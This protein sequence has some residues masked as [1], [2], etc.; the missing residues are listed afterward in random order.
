LIATAEAPAPEPQEKQQKPEEPEKHD[1][2]QQEA[3]A[4]SA[5]PPQAS[6]RIIWSVPL[7]LGIEASEDDAASVDGNAPVGSKSRRRRARR[8]RNR[9]A[10]KKNSA[11]SASDTLNGD[12][13]EKLLT[14]STHQFILAFQEHLQSISIISIKN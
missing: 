6:A 8:N 13:L 7:V 5:P 1:Q 11:H 4:T 9:R 14:L 3:L 12:T 2:E 10:N